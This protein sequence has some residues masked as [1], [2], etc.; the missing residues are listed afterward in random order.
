MLIL[1][2]L[3]ETLR[4]WKETPVVRVGLLGLYVGLGI[5]VYFGIAHFFKI[6]EV[7][8]ILRMLKKPLKE[9]PQDNEMKTASDLAD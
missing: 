1:Y 5:I 3:P 9:V 2:S 8:M 6:Q 7:H 4:R